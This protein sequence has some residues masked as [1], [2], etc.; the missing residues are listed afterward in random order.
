MRSAWGLETERPVWQTRARC[1]QPDVDPD[2]WHSVLAG[3][4]AEAAHICLKHCPVLAE[5]AGLDSV[6]SGGVQ[7]GQYWPQRGVDRPGRWV[8]PG[9]GCRLCGYS[10]AQVL[11]ESERV[12]QRLRKREQRG[13]A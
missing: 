13:A 11:A 7:A 1:A 8:K 2:M 3:E 6:P 9:D 12:R 10:A 4:L 5:C